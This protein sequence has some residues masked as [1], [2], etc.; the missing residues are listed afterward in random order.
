[1]PICLGEIQKTWQ[2]IKINGN[3]EE[4]VITPRWTGTYTRSTTQFLRETVISSVSQRLA[5]FEGTSFVI[6][7]FH[8]LWKIQHFCRIPPLA[9][10]NILPHFQIPTK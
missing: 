7:D 3:F 9:P 6:Q 2:E 10:E 5:V 8:A 4:Q 1:M